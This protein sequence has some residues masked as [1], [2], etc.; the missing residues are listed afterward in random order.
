MTVAVRHATQ[1]SQPNNSEK[2]VS[3]T[4]WNEDHVIEGLGSAA[5]ADTEDFVAIENIDRRA[6]ASRFYS[7][8]KSFALGN[9]LVFAGDAWDIDTHHKSPI[10]RGFAR[11]V[12]DEGGR[13]TRSTDPDGR[14][15]A[16]LQMRRQLFCWGADVTAVRQIFL[17]EAGKSAIQVTNS[18]VGCYGER[19]ADG[20]LEWIDETGP[21]STRL[22]DTGVP[23]GTL[24]LTH[25]LILGQSNSYGSVSGLAETLEPLSPQVLMCDAGARTFGTHHNSQT[26]GVLRDHHILP[27]RPA[28]ERS[29]GGA[30]ESPATAF[31]YEFI[32]R[33]PSTEAV[34]VSCHGVGG[35]SLDNMS[36]G[37]APWANALRTV[38]H[39][40][41][42]AYLA[43]CTLR[44]VAYLDQGENGVT[45]LSQAQKLSDLLAFQADLTEDVNALTGLSDEVPLA[46]V[47]TSS[48]IKY[49]GGLPATGLAQLQAGLDYPTRFVTVGARYTE[50]TNAADGVHMMGDGPAFMGSLGGRA[51]ADWLNEDD[52]EPLYAVSAVRSG[53]SVV[54]TFNRDI[55]IDTSLVTDPGQLGLKWL[56]STA[57]A[58][59]TGT[60]TKTGARQITAALSGVP[61]GSNPRIGI[62]TWGTALSDAGPTTG[63]RA[64]IRDTSTDVN[65]L[66]R[67]M[68]R[69]AAMQEV[70]VT[71]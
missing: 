52:A 35:Q 61:S 59:I 11:M 8:D 3:A 17:Q 21:N 19:I 10:Y 5:E 27:F 1:V 20:H 26:D 42:A 70:A 28:H 2:A 37:T 14:Q 44:V 40:R 71:T 36:R 24:T 53:T 31:G 23:R 49:S 63:A 15:H 29:D 48:F 33:R 13:I 57:S 51:I 7:S 62:A 64:C 66:E 38:M 32:T 16:G 68:H 50:A 54:L 46:L 69:Y 34:L 45:S 58:S 56:D 41:V 43:G 60:P 4:V 6:T 30:G 47:Q 65:H 12:L 55:E 67:T 22:Y 9:G 25:A 18:A 39:A